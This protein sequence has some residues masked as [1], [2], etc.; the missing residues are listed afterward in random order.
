VS[1]PAHSLD[2]LA[3][4]IEAAIFAAGGTGFTA[5]LRRVL[6]L[7]PGQ[8]DA[9]VEQINASLVA[10]GRPYAIIPVAGGYQFRTRPEWSE[11]LA[12]LTP[13]R[14]QKLSPAALD[15]LA[16]I[17]YRQPITRAEL[18]ELRSV[19]CDGVL[20][21]LI[22]RR[23]VRVMGRRDAP[24][25]PALYGTTP[26]FLEAFGMRALHELPVLRDVAAEAAAQGTPV[27]HS[28]AAAGPNGEAAPAALALAA[29]GAA[30]HGEST[31]AGLDPGEAEPNGAA[32]VLASDL[33]LDAETRAA[34]A[35]TQDLAVAE[36]A[37]ELPAAEL[38]QS[39]APEET[40]DGDTTPLYPPRD[41]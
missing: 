41:D 20:R 17:A 8:L 29:N 6:D 9:L 26:F 28:D 16:V 22:E 27:E 35:Q 31:G 1:S 37:H 38:T 39:E 14:K 33:E 21:A 18:E 12:E 40:A 34:E 23:M 24:G 36:A 25:R 3:A 10:Q 13:E 15:T 32:A 11:F 5:R 19:D 30:A 4:R 7:S 2:E